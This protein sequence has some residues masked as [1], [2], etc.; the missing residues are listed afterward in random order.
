MNGKTATIA[1]VGNPNVGK[2][3]VFNALTGLHQHTGNWP[4]KTVAGAVG[5]FYHKGQKYKLVDTPGTYSLFPHSKEEEVTASYI[6]GGDADLCVVVCDATALQRSLYLCLQVIAHYANTVVCRNLID[7]AQKN[8]IGINITRLQNMLQVPVVAISAK[9]NQGLDQLKSKIEN[10]D[11][12]RYELQLEMMQT[13]KNNEEKNVQLQ[14]DY[15]D[16]VEN[17]DAKK[18]FETE[19]KFN[20]LIADVNKIIGEAI[21]DVMQ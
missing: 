21:R 2:S 13:G 10:F 15:A 18:F 8:G 5:I 17:P 7:E 19:T 14:K 9:N 12:L 20:I 3:T 1:L 16:L 4:G 11:K 6:L